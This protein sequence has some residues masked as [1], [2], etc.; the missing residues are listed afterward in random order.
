MESEIARLSAR[1]SAFITSDSAMMEFQNATAELESVDAELEELDQ[2]GQQLV[3][4]L[5]AERKGWETKLAR[6]I[7]AMNAKFEAYFKMREGG[8]GRVE[9]N[10]DRNAIAE[11]GIRIRVKFAGHRG[12]C[13][14]VGRAAATRV[15]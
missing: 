7:R 5:E 3:E 10:Y 8:D 1:L 14:C 4:Q 9:L 11:A 6:Y 2:D 13:C 15:C 12:A